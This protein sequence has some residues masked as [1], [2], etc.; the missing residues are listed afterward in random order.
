MDNKIKKERTR[1]QFNI[2]YYLV[3]KLSFAG[4]IIVSLAVFFIAGF[5]GYDL[6]NELKL[7]RELVGL[8]VE[9]HRYFAIIFSC[10]FY[11]LI[12]ALSLPVSVFLSVA[13]GFIFGWFTGGLISVF[14]GVL[15]ATGIFLIARVVLKDLIKLGLMTRVESALNKVEDR[16]GHSSLRY[17][18]MMRL[19]PIVP[20]WLVNLASAFFDI[21]I[22]VYI[23]ATL[24]GIIPG[25]FIYSSLGE[26]LANS[27]E[28]SNPINLTIIYEPRILLPLIGCSLLLL[29]PVLY[30]KYKKE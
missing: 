25:A 1:G 3:L 7:K 15:G 12:C 22:K 29:L 30:R 9:R 13:S 24:I 21:P 4:V 17:L 5:D 19:I 27:L 26:G 18:L 2:S 14:G 28:T 6:I 16:L 23:S 20:F 8:F 10:F 11:A